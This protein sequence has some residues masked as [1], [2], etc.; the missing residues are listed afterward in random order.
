MDFA[1]ARITLSV[2]L[3]LEII[4]TC[5]AFTSN[6]FACARAAMNRSVAGGIAWSWVATRYQ[7]G[8]VF[9]AG[10]PDGETNASCENGRCSAHIWSASR[11]GRS[12]AKAVSK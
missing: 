6:V 10:S 1:A 2:A 11:F 4:G 9:Q 3:G 5:E 8:I 7:D 12:P